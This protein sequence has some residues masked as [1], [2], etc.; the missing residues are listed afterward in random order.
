MATLKVTIEREVGAKE[1]TLTLRFPSEFADSIIQLVK[2]SFEIEMLTAKTT[3]EGDDTIL[4][5]IIVTEEKIETLKTN[6][7][8]AFRAGSGIGNISLN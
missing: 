5:L 2:E 3:T 7:V 8:K 6:M 1:A 4:S